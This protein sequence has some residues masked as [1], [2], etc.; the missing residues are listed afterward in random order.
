[1]KKI[2]ETQEGRLGKIIFKDNGNGI[3]EG[4]VEEVL[5]KRCEIHPQED[6]ILVQM[7]KTEYEELLQKEKSY[8]GYNEILRR[9]DKK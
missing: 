3:L 2:L 8:D 1:M 7:S 9:Y 6:G 4:N 5:K